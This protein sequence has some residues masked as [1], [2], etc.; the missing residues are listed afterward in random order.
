MVKFN[1]QK[2]IFL[3]Y[4]YS[5]SGCIKDGITQKDIDKIL[6]RPEL[7]RIHDEMKLIF[8]KTK[9]NNFGFDTDLGVINSCR[10]E[11]LIK[12]IYETID[13]I[14]K[15]KIDVKHVV[16]A[17]IGGSELGAT[18]VI[19][20]CS[21]L[22]HGEI[23][24]YP[25]TSL[26]NDNISR[27]IDSIEPTK[28]ILILVSRSGGT[29]ESLT[30]YNVI[31]RYL[32]E[33][34]GKYHIR[35]CV[36]IL[37]TDKSTIANQLAEHTKVKIQGAMS[38]RF[39]SLHAANLFT[40]ALFGIDI[41]MIHDGALSILKN[42]VE[43]GLDFDNNISLSVAILK[44]LM[45]I[46]HE[47]IIFNTSVF[48]P[49]LVKYGDWL[50]Q[51][52]EE[53]LGHN[54]KIKIC[55]KTTELSNKLHSDFQNWWAGGDIFFHQFVFPIKS[56]SKLIKNPL[57][58]NEFLDDIEFAAF[59]GTVKSLA[60]NNRPSFITFLP[61]INEFYLGQLM[62][63]DM[64]SMIYLGELYG[65]GNEINIMG[66][67]YFNQP[68]VENYKKIMNELLKDKSKLHVEQKKIQKNL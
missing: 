44:Y 60:I 47:K 6:K 11:D 35:H 65:L 39:T 52:T 16:L 20:S 42:C 34:L 59:I 26:N 13:D 22:V 17:G 40:M 50:D 45:N 15:Y 24:Y 67:G 46:K 12:Y 41:K 21:K 55:T 68:G 4:D 8:S 18:A 53:S 10:D 19:E 5:M 54:S 56:D 66:K 9:K 63:R 62:M 36:A 48:S 14:K 38:G 58:E 3:N 43:T 64:I 61:E 33:K 32:E 49:K 29:K 23:K 51:L 57:V 28:T 2:S 7:K 27:I 30:S 31:K 1:E 37:G 25:I